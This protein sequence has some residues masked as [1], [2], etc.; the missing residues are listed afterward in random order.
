MWDKSTGEPYGNAIVWQ[1]TRTDKTRPHMR[2]L[3]GVHLALIAG[4]DAAAHDVVGAPSAA[5]G[6]REESPRYVR[7]PELL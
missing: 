1:D 7:P 2:H 5:S 3:E 4:L 6:G